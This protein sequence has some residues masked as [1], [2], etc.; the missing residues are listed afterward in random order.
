[1]AAAEGFKAVND[2]ISHDVGDKALA[3]YGR[4]LPDTITKCLEEGST[5]E[6]PVV[7]RTGGDELAVICVKSSSASFS[8]FEAQIKSMVQ[9]VAET[10]LFDAKTDDS[11]PESEWVPTFLRI[12][13]ASTFKLADEAET[14]VRTDIYRKGA[15]PHPFRLD[16]RA[17][18]V[19]ACTCSSCILTLHCSVWVSRCA[20]KDG[21]EVGA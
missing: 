15:P 3:E 7:F 12:G 16:R 10:V 11:A 20:W 2:R 19:T 18:H 4:L 8:D 9:K 21:Q 17:W 13:V 1:V 14:A 6:P 5:M